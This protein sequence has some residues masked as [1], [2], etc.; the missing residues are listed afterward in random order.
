MMQQVLDLM[1]AKCS[2]DY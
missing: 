1:A 2:N